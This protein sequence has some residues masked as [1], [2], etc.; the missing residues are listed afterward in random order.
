MGKRYLTTESVCQGILINCVD[1][2][3]ENI[4]ACLKK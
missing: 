1:I 3:A 2:I 4:D